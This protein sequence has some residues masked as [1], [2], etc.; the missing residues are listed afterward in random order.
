MAFRAPCSRAT[1]SLWRFLQRC[2]GWESN[3][4]FKWFPKY[5]WRKWLTLQMAR[6]AI[7]ERFRNVSRCSG[8]FLNFYSFSTYFWHLLFSVIPFSNTIKFCF[9][10]S[11][12]FLFQNFYNLFSENLLHYLDCISLWT[13]LK[14]GQQN[15]GHIALYF[16]KSMVAI[17]PSKKYSNQAERVAPFGHKENPP[18]HFSSSQ[19]CNFKFI[20][21]SAVRGRIKS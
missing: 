1:S 15:S 14:K 17:S 4:R 18:G 10:F 7:S 19:K 13:C 9:F 11:S 16:R 3:L 2:Q 5:F 6:H 12:L 8:D 21:F 20:R